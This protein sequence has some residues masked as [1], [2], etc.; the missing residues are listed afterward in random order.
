MKS[1]TPALS[2]AELDTVIGGKDSARQMSLLASLK[3][4]QHDMAKALIQNLRV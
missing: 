3:Q 2:D 1:E 4:L